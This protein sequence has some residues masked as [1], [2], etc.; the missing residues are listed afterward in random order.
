MLRIFLYSLVALQ[1]IIVLIV[2]GIGLFDT[3]LNFR[4]IELN[5]NE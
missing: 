5:K 3:W 2:I 4:K 1:Q